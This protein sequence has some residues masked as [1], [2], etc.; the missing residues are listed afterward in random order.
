MDEG[1]KAF[2]VSLQSPVLMLMDAPTPVV[3]LAW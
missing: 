3:L 2:P 1:R